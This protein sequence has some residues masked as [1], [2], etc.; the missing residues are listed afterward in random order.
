MLYEL[1]EGLLQA[2]AVSGQR[3]PQPQG[4]SAHFTGAK[5]LPFL[6]GTRGS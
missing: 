3:S 5:V 2:R 6:A 1:N 4:P